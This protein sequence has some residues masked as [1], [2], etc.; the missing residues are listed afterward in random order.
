MLRIT[1]EGDA[2]T[3]SLKLEGRLEGAWVDVLRKAWHEVTAG[4][5]GRALTIDVGAVSFA[6]RE[7]RALLLAIERDGAILEKVS[8]FLRHVLAE[9]NNELDRKG[10]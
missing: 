4:L 7:G 5:G 2:G 3:M 8:G 9:N 10:E 1:Q 6:D